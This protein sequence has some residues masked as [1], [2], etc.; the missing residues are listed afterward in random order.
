MCLTCLNS[1]IL[2]FELWK[3]SLSQKTWMITIFLRAPCL[4]KISLL[5]AKCNICLFLFARDQYLFKNRPTDGPPNSFYRSLYP[6]IIQDI[7]VTLWFI[8]FIGSLCL[9]LNFLCCRRVLY[10]S[11]IMEQV[12]IFSWTPGANVSQCTVCSFP[13]SR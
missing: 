10:W 3:L 11:K 4:N 9:V 13:Q 2:L 5:C 6:K 1:E 7:E 8:C 12:K